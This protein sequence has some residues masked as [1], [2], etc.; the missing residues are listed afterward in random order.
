[1]QNIYAMRS[2][3]KREYPSTR[4]ESFEKHLGDSPQIE[5]LPWKE[6]HIVDRVQMQQGPQIGTTKSAPQAAETQGVTDVTPS[7]ASQDALKDAKQVG[8]PQWWG[9]GGMTC[10]G[11][12][13]AINLCHFLVA[14]TRIWSGFKKMIEAQGPFSNQGWSDL[15][16]LV[17]GRL[18]VIL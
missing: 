14:V 13:E 3:T 9:P 11:S 6:T 17:N 8:M 15:K 5:L 7:F 4:H 10:G 16:R 18:L 2:M 1:M 12:I